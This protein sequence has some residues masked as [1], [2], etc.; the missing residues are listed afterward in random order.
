MKIYK[1][2]HSKLIVKLEKKKKNEE[3]TKKLKE[4]QDE[5]LGRF[6]GDRFNELFD[7]DHYIEFLMGKITEKENHYYMSL[8][9]SDCKNFTFSISPFESEP[10]N[11]DLE[12]PGNLWRY[13]ILVFSKGEKYNSKYSFQ[14]F[15]KTVAYYGIKI[16]KA[17][18]S[19]PE[20][21]IFNLE[22]TKLDKFPVQFK[23][24]KPEEPT[25]VFDGDDFIYEPSLEEQ[26][27]DIFDSIDKIR[28]WL[29]ESKK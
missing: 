13:I 28:Y 1:P 25:Y 15:K 17:A 24:N 18:F 10:E 5:E 26:L 4:E 23:N 11:I 20:N 3:F 27:L 16:E 12:E 7:D 29:N 22:F 19:D 21:K 14:A 6:L 9:E 2:H 8:T